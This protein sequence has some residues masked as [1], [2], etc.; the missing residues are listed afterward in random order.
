MVSLGIALSS[1]TTGCGFHIVNNRSNFS[2]ADV[3]P[4]PSLPPPIPSPPSSR[5][6]RKHVKSFNNQ[7]KTVRGVALTR[8]TSCLYIKG[9][10]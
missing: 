8:G 7:Y 1:E 5:P 6:V 4:A 3:A 2:E 9:E 10:K